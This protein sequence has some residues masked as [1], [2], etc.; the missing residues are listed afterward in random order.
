MMSRIPIL[1]Y[2]QMQHTR[3]SIER[4]INH[5]PELGWHGTFGELV[6]MEERGK[7]EPM[8]E[9]KFLRLW[10]TLCSNQHLEQVRMVYVSCGESEKGGQWSY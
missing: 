3:V 10:L 6:C 1:L 4:V 5:D 8:A 9:E 7:T 2:I